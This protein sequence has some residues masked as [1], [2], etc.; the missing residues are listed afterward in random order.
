[1]EVQATASNGLEDGSETD[2][3]SR[4]KK[5]TTGHHHQVD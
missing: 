2:G 4:K 5:R 1:M 3:Y